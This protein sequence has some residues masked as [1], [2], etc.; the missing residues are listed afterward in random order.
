[1]GI[2][3]CCPLLPVVHVCDCRFHFRL[4][5]RLSRANIDCINIVGVSCPTPMPLLALASELRHC[6]AASAPVH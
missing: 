4:H 3:P 6:W 2:V 1:M 5:P